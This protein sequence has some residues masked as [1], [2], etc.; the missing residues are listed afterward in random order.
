MVVKSPPP[1]VYIVLGLLLLWGGHR[2]W[3]AGYVRWPQGIPLPQVSLPGLGGGA[4]DLLLTSGERTLFADSSP[5]ATAAAELLRQGNLSAAISVLEMGLQS[6]RNDPEARIFLNNAR[7]Q[8]QGSPLSLAVV[9]PISSNPNR[10]KETLRGVAQAQEELFQQ[11]GIGGRLL[12][13]VIA[14]DG[15]NPE[16]AAAVAKALVAQPEI[17]G[18]IGHNTSDAT[19]AAAEV[20]QPAGLAMISSTSTS[21]RI[22]MLGDAIF[23][24]VP[25]DQVAGTQLARYALNTLRLQRVAIFYNPNSAYSSSLRDAF[26]STLTSEGG[27]VLAEFDLS[28]SDFNPQASLQRAVGQGAQVAFLA[29]TASVAE[30]AL[31]VA[32]ENAVAGKPLALLGGD[33]LF[34]LTTLQEGGAAVEGLVVA[35]P[36]HPQVPRNRGFAQ[37]AA[38]LWGGQVSWRTALAY[39]ATRVFLQAFSQG[40][41]SRNAVLA[42]LQDPNFLLQDGASGEVRFLPSGDRNAPYVLVRVEPGNRSGTGYDFVPLP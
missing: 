5:T 34:S 7:A 32:R 1:I 8:Q 18:V 25:S 30:K 38:Q 21:T 29:P 6:N 42:R 15:D 41:T 14:D 19:L 33:V 3:R 23:R 16:R 9:V 11:G 22:S 2:A 28:A 31:A 10:A 37:K 17:L 36:W 26:A 4:Q 12:R 40:A 39:D 24:T 27:I 35:V 13:V 20:Y